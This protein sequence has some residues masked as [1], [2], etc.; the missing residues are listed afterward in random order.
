L[1]VTQDN[2]AA[3]RDNNESNETVGKEE[4][5]AWTFKEVDVVIALGPAGVGQ[6]GH[7]ANRWRG[8]RH[9]GQGALDVDDGC[10]SLPFSTPPKLHLT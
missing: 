6:S 8:S 1:S 2:P 9:D 7:S 10:Q 3:G 4:S 5:A